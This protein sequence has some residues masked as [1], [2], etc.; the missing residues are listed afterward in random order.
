MNA[1][2]SWNQKTANQLLDAILTTVEQ[3]GEL[4]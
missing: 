4:K 3:A 1:D 2:I